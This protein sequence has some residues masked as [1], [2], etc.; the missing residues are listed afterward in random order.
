MRHWGE[1]VRYA[2]M[3]DF[4]DVTRAAYAAAAVCPPTAGVP[5][6]LIASP[7]QFS[8]MPGMRP[9]GPAPT[10]GEHTEEVLA[11]LGVVGG[12]ALAQLAQVLRGLRVRQGV[13]ASLLWRRRGS[14]GLPAT[15][16]A[17]GRCFL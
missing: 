16:S 5:W 6:D 2:P 7:V 4:E 3:A 17:D 15:V 8:Q 13:A 12:R 14:H 1:E 10:H 9:A 11:E